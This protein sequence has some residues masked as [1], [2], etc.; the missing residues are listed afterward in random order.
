MLLAWNAL[1]P[2]SPREP[3]TMLYTLHKIIVIHTLYPEYV[4]RIWN[5]TDTQAPTA[6]TNLVGH[7]KLRL[8]YHGQLQ[9]MWNNRI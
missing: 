2:V 8:T 5:P 9:I 3:E 6:P 4:Q 1:D 7:H